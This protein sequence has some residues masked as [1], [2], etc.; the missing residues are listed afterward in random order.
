MT[1]GNRVRIIYKLTQKKKK[2]KKK[3][4]KLSCLSQFTNIHY[5]T[6]KMKTYIEGCI[7]A[8]CQLVWYMWSNKFRSLG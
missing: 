2:E 8:Y 3:K 6:P 7:E 4:P 1:C 5:H